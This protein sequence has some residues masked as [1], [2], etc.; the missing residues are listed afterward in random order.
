MLSVWSS[1]ATVLVATPICEFEAR[2][3]SICGMRQPAVVL[4]ICTVVAL[5]QAVVSIVAGAGSV[6]FSFSLKDLVSCQSQR[7]E[8][9]FE[10]TSPHLG[11][12]RD[13]VSVRCNISTGTRST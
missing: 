5:R 7:R 3:L 8:D 1:D 12:Y 6:H 2:L 13:I 4:P 9:A 10:L 11:H